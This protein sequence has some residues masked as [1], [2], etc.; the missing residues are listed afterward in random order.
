VPIAD[1]VSR[2]SSCAASNTNIVAWGCQLLAAGG[3]LGYKSGG[4][5][6]DGINSTQRFVTHIAVL[7]ALTEAA[8]DSAQFAQAM[9]LTSTQGFESAGG[10]EL[11]G[12]DSALPP[13]IA[14]FARDKIVSVE[15]GVDAMRRRRETPD[16]ASPGRPRL[17]VELTA[18]E[19]ERVLQL[20]ILEATAVDLENGLQYNALTGLSVASFVTARGRQTQ[21]LTTTHSDGSASVNVH[22]PLGKDWTDAY[23]TWN[24]A[25]VLSHLH[26]HGH[27]VKLVIPSVLCTSETADEWTSAR[28]YSLFL[29]LHAIGNLPTYESGSGSPNRTYLERFGRSNLDHMDIPVASPAEVPELVTAIDIAVRSHAS[30]NC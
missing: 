29:V 6:I 19:T 21:A 2:I 5:Y 20:N 14:S 26:N 11:V 23:M 12:T 8:V 24:M 18:S 27:M 16:D 15:N 28:T 9:V 1:L 13:E 25:Y 3:E 17:C 10:L 4:G 22:W 7:N 30:E